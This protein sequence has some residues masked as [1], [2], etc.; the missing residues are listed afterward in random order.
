MLTSWTSRVATA[1]E[2]GKSTVFLFVFQSVFTE[3]SLRHAFIFV[4]HAEACYKKK[5]LTSGLR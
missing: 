5:H 3:F 2:F 4:V 1:I